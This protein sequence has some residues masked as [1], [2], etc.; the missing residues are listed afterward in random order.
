MC[1][2]IL[3]QQDAG[4]AAL[5]LDFRSRSKLHGH[6]VFVV[7]MLWLRYSLLRGRNKLLYSTRHNLW[8]AVR[9]NTPLLVATLTRVISR[10]NI[11][12]VPISLITCAVARL[13]EHSH[14]DLITF[15]LLL[16]IAQIFIDLSLELIVHTMIIYDNVKHYSCIIPLTSH[17]RTSIPHSREKRERLNIPNPNVNLLPTRLNCAVKQSERCPLDKV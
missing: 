4:C 17:Q 10:S 13:T 7:V 1:I 15:V 8:G 3:S 11:S 16:L 12:N 2:S 5:W 6:E 14:N 9:D